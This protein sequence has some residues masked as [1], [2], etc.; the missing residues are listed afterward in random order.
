MATSNKGTWESWTNK[1]YKLKTAGIHGESARYTVQ[2]VK[3]VDFGSNGGGK[4]PAFEVRR[5]VEPET[6]F[7]R[8]CDIFEKQFELVEAPKAKEE[9]AA[10]S[11]SQ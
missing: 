9:V 10:S 2:G 7:I 3:E 5:L 4:K 11:P 8:A 6:V 1:T